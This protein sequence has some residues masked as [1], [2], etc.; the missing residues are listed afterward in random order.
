MKVRMKC[1][2]Y[3]INYE[4]AMSNHG[5]WDRICRVIER[6]SE[7]E[8]LVIGFLGGSITMGSLSSTPQTC[9]AYHVY[10]WW[11]RT[12]PNA[13]FSYINAGIGATDSQFGCAR[14]ES[15]LLRYEPDF[16]VVDFSVNDES[17]EHFLET[18]EGVIRKLY[19]AEKSL[20]SCCCIMSIIMTVPTH[21]YSMQRSR[22][23]TIFRR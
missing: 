9:Y 15:D 10:E 19:Y 11:C 7:G 18:Y 1:M 6:A 8:S 17:T 21:S 16:V 5:N 23:I 13:K 12:F 4:N 3:Q 22:V 14:A 2:K 20:R